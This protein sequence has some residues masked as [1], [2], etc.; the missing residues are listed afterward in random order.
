MINADVVRYFVSAVWSPTQFCIRRRININEVPFCYLKEQD[1]ALNN[2]VALHLRKFCWKK[3]NSISVGIL[4]RPSNVFSF[5]TG[6]CSYTILNIIFSWKV[7]RLTTILS[8]NVTKWSL[9]F[10][11]V[12]HEVHT[13]LPLVLQC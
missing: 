7:H 11:T 4:W 10:N 9:F 13:L 5:F 8:W 12:P 6:I 1:T 3:K 2:V